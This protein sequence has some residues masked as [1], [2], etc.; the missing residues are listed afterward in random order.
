[1]ESR[2]AL[3]P[4]V[5]SIP[6]SATLAITGRARELAAAGTAVCNFAA[7]EPDFDT[8]EPIKAAAAAA[9]RAGR[10]KYTPA[11]GLTELRA[12]IARKLR[13]DNG[14]DYGP[15]RIV[16]SNGGKQ[17]I[18]NVIMALCAPGD[19]IVIPAPYW[20]SYPEMVRVAG[21]AAVFAPA[22]EANGFKLTP[23]ELRAVLTPRAKALILNSP[24]NPS[25]LVYTENELRALAEVAV[26]HDL[27]ILSDEIYETMVYDAAR[28]VS[29]ASLS[30]E[31]FARTVTLNGFSKAFSMTGWRLGY[32]AGPAPLMQ[33]VAALQSHS[34]SGPNTFAQ[35]GALEALRLGADWTR[36][37][38][39]V[40][41]ERRGRLYD[42]LT[43]LPGVTCVKPMGAFYMLPNIAACG[44]DALTF[45]SRLLEDEAVAVVP[46][47]P[48]GAAANVR[49]SYACD[50][51]M[52][53]DGMDRVARFI[54][55]L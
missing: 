36:E 43:R 29:V 40:F 44:L 5:A 28:H 22:R 11:A 49:L 1:M 4:N 34:T 15:G 26:E 13:E 3:N 48:F 18:F 50:T 51:D 46:G 10:T 12:A 38:T 47:G 6:P 7:G 19:E 45:A 23:A 52:I 31:I 33:A 37:M 8:P 20:L 30:P 2:S 14:L 21:G 17:A 39:A 9:L 24:S 55:N 41:A 16:V 32:A 25:G 42:R 53:E 27:T 35:Y 54:T